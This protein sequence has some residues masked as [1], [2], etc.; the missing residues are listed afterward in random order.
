MSPL[1]E[2]EKVEQ[3]GDIV[4]PAA[5]LDIGHFRTGKVKNEPNSRV[6]TLF[7]KGGTNSG[8]LFLDN[9]PL[10]GNCLC[11]ADI[12]NELLDCWIEDALEP[13][14]FRGGGAAGQ[15]RT[16]RHDGHNPRR[17]QGAKWSM[18]GYRE[19]R[20]ATGSKAD[21]LEHAR[22]EAIQRPVWIVLYYG[23]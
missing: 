6:V 22:Y 4:P 2:R 11:R 5:Q 15:Q 21:E 9:S 17:G 13:R 3:L 16:G 18:K 14:S 8:A 12:S 23:P 7:S 19:R 10:I 1:S 20:S